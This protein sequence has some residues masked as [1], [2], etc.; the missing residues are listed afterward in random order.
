M[1]KTHLF[2]EPLN[3]VTYFTVSSQIGLR[4]GLPFGQ[5]AHNQKNIILLNKFKQVLNASLL[6]L[7]KNKTI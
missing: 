1:P 6:F 3:Y 7:A 2:S 5:V 4:L